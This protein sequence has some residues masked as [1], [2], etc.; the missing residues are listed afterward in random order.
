MPARKCNNEDTAM[1]IQVY[2]SFQ[3]WMYRVLHELDAKT[4]GQV[5]GWT[6]ASRSG[7]LVGKW[8]HIHQRGWA[9]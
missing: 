5:K 4:K 1:T 2:R 3:D 6:V 8:D 9:I 7:H